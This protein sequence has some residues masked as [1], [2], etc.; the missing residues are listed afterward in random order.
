[1]TS[2]RTWST[3]A[4][5]LTPAS[6]PPSQELPV[7]AALPR[8][9][10]W[11]PEEH[12][13]SNVHRLEGFFCKF[14]TQYFKGHWDSVAAVFVVAKIRLLKTFTAQILLRYA[15]ICSHSIRPTAVDNRREL[16]QLILFRLNSTHA[17]LSVSPR[18]E[19]YIVLL[20]MMIDDQTPR[21]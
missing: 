8:C 15:P 5:L 3:D 14:S 20:I 7:A 9:L 16:P 4:A 13:D 19:I 21:L 6:R 12:R 11:W 2:K 1:M 10:G 18:L 17:F